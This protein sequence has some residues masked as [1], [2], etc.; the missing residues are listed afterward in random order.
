MTVNY[1]EYIR[2]KM[3]FMKKHDHDYF[4]ETSPM[5]EYGEYWKTYTF[6]DGAIWYEKMSSH[7]EQVEVVV[8]GAK[9][10]V[11]VKL[12]RTEFWNTEQPTSKFYYEQ[13]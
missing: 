13:F 3:E 2:E 8:L 7:F 5:N 9:C 12:F 11:D 1:E 10:K 6:K 4:T